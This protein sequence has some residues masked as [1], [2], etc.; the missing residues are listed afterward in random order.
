M[1]VVQGKTGEE[2]QKMIRTLREELRLEE[3]R[4]VLLKKLRQSQMQKENLV[5][6]VS[7]SPT[8]CCPIHPLYS[9]AS[10]IHSLIPL[11]ST[12]HSVTLSATALIPLSL[13]HCTHPSLTLSSTTLNPLLFSQPP[14]SSLSHSL[15]LFSLTYCFCINT[16]HSGELACT[17][18]A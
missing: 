11:A 10:V 1:C 5:Q 9:S 7:H 16:L 13:S 2:R 4:L 14:H 6:K 15:I 3:A 12:A 8:Q 18:R 17:D